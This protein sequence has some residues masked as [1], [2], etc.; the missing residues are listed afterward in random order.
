[1]P[2][3]RLT[4]FCRFTLDPTVSLG[5]VSETLPFTFTGADLYALCSDAM[6]KAVTRSARSVDQR[7]AAINSERAG[8]GQGK[9]SVAY[10]FDHYGT[11]ADAEVLVTEEDFIRAKSEL[12]PSVSV[13]ELRHYE[14]V[15]SSFEGT[16]K[17]SQN[18]DGGAKNQQYSSSA[19]NG[20]SNARNRATEAMR[21]VNKNKAPTTNGADYSHLV[22]QPTTP[23]APDT[24]DDDYVIRTDR[25]SLKDGPARLSPSKGKGKGKSREMPEED[26]PAA[27]MNNHVNTGVPDEDLYD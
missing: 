7:V 1:M 3:S 15:R 14:R 16:D 4:S 19:P 6:L 2:D 21:R 10:Y 13:D 18:S 20:P 12:V 26:A 17:T 25:M 5:R 22:Q 8:R 9:I 23:A 24:D 27:H 11:E